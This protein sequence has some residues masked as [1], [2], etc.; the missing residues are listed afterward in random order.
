[1]IDTTI[2]VLEENGKAVCYTGEQMI[3]RQGLKHLATID[4]CYWIANILNGTLD[5]EE[6]RRDM[7]IKKENNEYSTV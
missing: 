4:P 3:Y 2:Y 7:G 6:E 5:L 1:M